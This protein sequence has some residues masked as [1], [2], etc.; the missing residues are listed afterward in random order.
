MASGG[1]IMP[2]NVNTGTLLL[3]KQSEGSAG[4]V[5]NIG[6]RANCIC[7]YPQL[8]NQPVPFLSDCIIE[9]AC[10]KGGGTLK[11]KPGYGDWKNGLEPMTKIGGGVDDDLKRFTECVGCDKTRFKSSGTDYNGNPV[12]APKMF[13][14]SYSNDDDEYSDY[15]DIKYLTVGESNALSPDFVSHFSNDAIQSNLKRV[16][17]PCSFDAFTNKP[18]LNGECRLIASPGYKLDDKTKI[19]RVS[20]ELEHR[21]YHCLSSSKNVITMTFSDDYL[22]NNK[23]KYGNACFTATPTENAVRYNVVNW[24]NRP[25]ESP[26]I[27]TTVPEIGSVVPIETMTPEAKLFLKADETSSDDRVESVD[28]ED[29]DLVPKCLTLYSAPIPDTA[30]Q[31]PPILTYRLYREFRDNSVPYPG[32]CFYFFSFGT[33]RTRIPCKIYDLR[34]N[35][36]V[37]CGYIGKDTESVNV[38]RRDSRLHPLKHITTFGEME[39]YLSDGFQVCGHP[40]WYSAK[41]DERR[42]GWLINKNISGPQSGYEKFT[43]IILIDQNKYART[44]WPSR[45]RRN[46]WKERTT[47]VTSLPAIRQFVEP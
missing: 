30:I 19:M 7:K 25:R 35:D 37:P 22:R 21:I 15:P 44:F 42:F 20:N 3:V 40:A 33:F 26:E 43:G 36:I 2:C 6:Y 34:Y 41:P 39:K 24:F 45:R 47:Y 23:G 1:D 32:L 8:V 17:D 9:R 5:G 27:N 28:N 13:S 31:L 14:E 4:E 16:P 11:S 12:C 46:E 18:Y 29:G 38:P 10:R